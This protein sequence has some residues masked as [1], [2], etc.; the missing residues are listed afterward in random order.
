M[1]KEKKSQK[2]KR[3]ERP[4]RTTSNINKPDGLTPEEW[5]VRLREEAATTEVLTVSKMEPGLFAVG[6]VASFQRYEVVWRGSNHPLNSCSCMDFK[7]SQLGT[8]KHM[9]AVKSRLGTRHKKVRLAADADETTIYMDYSGTPRLRIFYAGEDAAHIMELAENIFGKDG[10]ADTSSAGFLNFRQFINKLEM[11]FLRFRCTPDA[12]A[13]VDRFFDDIARKERLDAV[14][15]NEKWWTAYLSEGITPYPYQTEGI[16]FAARSGRCLIADEM[17]LG[18]TLQAIG[19]A[20]L[21]YREGFVSSILVVCPTSLKYQWQKE[22]SKFCGEEALVI[23]GNATQ[24]KRM[25]DMDCAFKIVSYNAL[26]NDLKLSKRISVDM[27]ILDEVQRLKN[28]STQ[29]A[30]TAR[31]IEADYKIILSGTP[32]ENKLEELYSVV[33]LVD[34]FILGPYYKFKARYIDTDDTGRIM[35]YK[36]LNEVGQRLRPIMIRRRKTAVALQMPER[37]DKNLL[38]P[39][40]DEQ[41]AIHDEYKLEVAKLIHKWRNNH[42]LSDTDRRRLLLSLC[43]MRMVCDS[44]FIIDQNYRHDTKVDEAVSIISSV[45][46]TGGEKVVLFSQWERMTRLVTAELDKTGIRYEYL[47]G[48]VPSAKRKDIMDRFNEDADV[49]VFVSTDAGSTGLNL[50]TACYVINMDLPWNP[51]V[52]EQR[53][54]RIYRIGQKRNIQVISLVAKDTIEEQMLSKLHFKSSMFAGVMDNGRDEINLENSKLQH[55]VDQ[56]DFSSASETSRQ[57][58]DAPEEKAVHPDVTVPMPDG[59]PETIGGDD[60]SLSEDKRYGMVSSV[61]DDT[62]T[63]QRTASVIQEGVSFLSNLAEILKSPEATQSLVDS[64][65]KEDEKTGETVL[66]IPVKDKKTVELLV[67]VI[68]KLL[69]GQ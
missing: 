23:E 6:N 19:T 12:T 58:A 62:P 64:L 68:G 56:F 66:R 26:T 18:K 16:R 17:G 21:L 14:F 49:R 42:F 47:H 10:F 24:R 4:R 9:E 59:T 65:V 25:Y 55:I 15:S 44:T 1:N 38:V 48:G 41:M 53:I 29:I 11:S 67:G 31:R 5:Q 54:G 40:T 3:E 45:V 13:F 20:A 22:I 7:T 63:R 34:Q 57:T 61:A 8:C 32:M 28:W 60:G 37:M 33:Q 46:E 69:R 51:A 35:G 50:Q 52:L 36:R 43:N 27:I 2:Q 30:K 39:M